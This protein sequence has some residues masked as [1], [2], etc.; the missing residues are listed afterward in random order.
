MQTED[1]D[2]DD[3]F[4]PGGFAIG[5]NNWLESLSWGDEFGKTWDYGVEHFKTMKPEEL[6]MLLTASYYVVEALGSKDR[7][8]E[9]ERL[10]DFCLN[11]SV[12]FM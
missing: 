2:I 11:F 6:A 10:Y 9:E 4:Q 3:D 1:K 7:T 12:D 5:P 8:H